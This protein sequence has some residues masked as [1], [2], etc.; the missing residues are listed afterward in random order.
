MF[1]IP[2]QLRGGM[3]AALLCA[4]AAASA[5]SL[6]ILPASPQYMEPVYVRISPERGARELI[7]GAQASMSGNVITVDVQK[8]SD[9]CEYYYDVMLGR[10]PAGT[11][12]VVVPV[13][14][15]RSA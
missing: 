6:A 8:R 13:G 14:E 9:C 11:Y 3:V 10:F 2:K 12:K 1:K 15:G 5:Q 7:Y 4:S